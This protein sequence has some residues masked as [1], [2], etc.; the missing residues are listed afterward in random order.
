MSTETVA[1][2]V[3]AASALGA[4]A[5]V[6]IITCC[7]LFLWNNWNAAQRRTDNQ[8][9]SKEILKKNER[10]LIVYEDTVEKVY[11]ALSDLKR[12]QK[13]Q[14]ETGPK[15]PNAAWRE[16]NGQIPPGT[17]QHK[18][19][20][21]VHHIQEKL[22]TRPGQIQTCLCKSVQSNPQDKFHH[23]N[24]CLQTYRKPKAPRGG[25]PS[26]SGYKAKGVKANPKRVTGIN[27]LC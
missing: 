2:L 6:V 26:S 13:G 12:D 19:F 7:S 3:I 21:Q 16:D 1:T 10:D 17:A 4:T 15:E 9:V 23:H 25:L 5:V 24:W 22:E 8:N 11:L 18:I 20:A 27:S 14:R